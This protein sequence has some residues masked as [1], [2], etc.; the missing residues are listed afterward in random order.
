MRRSPACVAV[1]LLCAAAL[2]AAPCTPSPTT[3]C[4]NDS[5][6]EV[7]VSWRDSRGR[8]GVGQAKSIT[9]DT[10]YFWFFSEANI[11]LVIK[12]LDARSINQKFWVFFGALSSVEYDLT[13]TDTTTGAVKT[14]HN[15]LGQFASVGDTG[16]FSPAP[17]APGDETVQ[18][19]GTFA[20]PESLE[21]IG[22]FIGA[23]ASSAAFA[24]CPAAGSSLLLNNCRFGLSVE[25]AD[26]RGRT[27]R[28]VPVQLTNDTGYFWFFSPDNVELVVKV[29]DARPV[30]GKIWV[31][32]GAL[33]AVEY[34]ITVRDLATTS[35]KRY[36]NPSG[37][38][39]S[40]GDTEAFRG[41]YAVTPTR[42]PGRAVS[43]DLDI[44]GG[45]VTATGADGTVFTLQ[46]PPDALPAPETVTL[47]PV[48]RLDHFPF[49]EGLVA[50][51]EIE[52]EGLD[53]MVPA[54]LTIRP[55]SSP[56][57]DRTLPYSYG[58]GGEDFILYPRDV[59]TSSLRLPLVRFAGYGVGQ[60]DPT[61]AASQVERVPSGPLAPYLQRYAQAVLLRV[62]GL[63]SQ[64]E[65]AERLAQ[66]HRDAVDERIR[67]LFTPVGGS[68]VFE[69]K[70]EMCRLGDW[71]FRTGIRVGMEIERQ[72]E[73]MGNATDEQAALDPFIENIKVCIQEAFDRCVTNKDPYEVLLILQFTRQLQLLGL[74]D[75][76]LTTY[77][78]GS[79]VERCLRF[80]LDF[81]SKVLLE[82]NFEGAS[83]T[84]RQKYR[85][86]HVPLRFSYGGN[87]YADRE[88]FEGA[89][90]LLPVDVSLDVSHQSEDCHVTVGSPVKGWFDA[91]A[92]W[93]G[94]QEQTTRSSVKLLYF[95]SSP[96]VGVTL[97]CGGSSL[98]FPVLE[99]GVDYLTLHQNEVSSNYL[100]MAPDWEQ[101]RFGP[102]PSQ[103]GE[104]FAR[105]TYQRTMSVEEGTL[106]EET[107][108]FLKHTPD[109]PMPECP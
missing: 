49:S 8:T 53:L 103:N 59:D 30:N 2:S 56:P 18:V 24:P 35:V 99:F 38:F 102:G 96:P 98:P 89:C 27:G 57:V 28:G 82:T 33:S 87:S 48:S 62:R 6:F 97:R 36:E 5:R 92:M 65:L 51:V 29:L 66:I 44:I 95:P 108:F 10:G 25:W 90:T 32:F 109:A 41:G 71:D 70:V 12:V 104:F 74:D 67:P 107:W 86:Q 3:L 76:L 79:F 54:T 105:K 60:G 101:L 1:F 75:E 16:A 64:A 11:E 47:V 50:G 14:Y 9:A 94:V 34:S 63:I 100:I 15:P 93:I 31:F 88:V 84:T 13:V 106:T 78:E 83:L 4:L 55:N 17:P 85:A 81:E 68:P 43:A 80:E 37:T 52:P 40:V 46:L 7:E 39:A 58:R 73:M 20:P 91:G 72:R 61:E 21:A 23:P 69:R 19:E 77:T 22:R 45:S 42:D 26:S